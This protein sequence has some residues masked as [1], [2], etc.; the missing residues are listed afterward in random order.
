MSHYEAQREAHEAAMSQQRKPKVAGV[1]IVPLVNA[2][3]QARM[4]MGIKKYGVALQA[5]NGRNALWDAYQEA[6]DLACYL[7]QRIEEEQPTLRKASRS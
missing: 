1:D 5:G 7:R 2:D 3:L 4:R 6:L